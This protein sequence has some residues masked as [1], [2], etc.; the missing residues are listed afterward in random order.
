MTK[1]VI[2]PLVVP[3]VSLGS[4]GKKSRHKAYFERLKKTKKLG[5]FVRP[6]QIQEVSVFGSTGIRVLTACYSRQ[7]IQVEL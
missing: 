7:M 4:L 6:T 2:L 1:L 3:E 5:A